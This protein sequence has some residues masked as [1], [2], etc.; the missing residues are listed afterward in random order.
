MGL[1]QNGNKRVARLVVLQVGA[2]AGIM[3]LTQI[4]A[5]L[6]AQHWLS[7]RALEVTCFVIGTVLTAAKGIEMFFSKTVAMFK[8]HEIPDDLDQNDLVA[9]TPNPVK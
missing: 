1:F 8:N 4:L 3:V 5:N 9:P 7:Q 6:P 2:G